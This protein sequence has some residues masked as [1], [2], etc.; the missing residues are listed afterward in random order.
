MIAVKPCAAR[1]SEVILSDFFAGEDKT[2]PIG[3]E[4]LR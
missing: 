3:F 4:S 1:A 2:K